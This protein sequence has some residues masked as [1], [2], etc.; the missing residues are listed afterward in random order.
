MPHAAGGGASRDDTEDAC[1]ANVGQIPCKGV[2]VI[3][4]PWSPTR[5]RGAT[6]GTAVIAPFVPSAT[7]GI[8]TGA[9]MLL[10]VSQGTR[11]EEHHVVLDSERHEL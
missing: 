2:Y 11:W 3:S 8:G 4:Q 7:R 9:W 5:A 1:D 6:G 10:S